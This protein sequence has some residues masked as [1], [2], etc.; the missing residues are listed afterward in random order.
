MIFCNFCRLSLM[1]VMCTLY[2]VE[3]WSY[4]EIYCIHKCDGKAFI[5]LT[6]LLMFLTYDFTWRW[7]T[8]ETICDC[9]NKQLLVI[10]NKIT[11]FQTFAMFWMLYAFFWV[12]PL[13]LN[14]I[15]QRS[16]HSVYSIF[17]GL[18]RWNR[19]S[20]LNHWHIK[21]RHRG[22]IQKKSYNN[23]IT[24]M[25]MVLF[26]FCC[27]RCPCFWKIH[28]KWRRTLFLMQF[29]HNGKIFHTVKK[30]V[31]K[32][33]DMWLMDRKSFGITKFEGSVGWH[34]TLSTWHLTLLEC[35]VFK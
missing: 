6:L 7:P 17:I 35:Y 18:W 13:C 10:D 2:T 4:T 16:E 8:V 26:S 12:I 28:R 11:W 9:E 22:I 1:H 3:S 5:N 19:Q 29:N 25:L 27:W 33:V 14:I 34:H 20:V 23:K 31:Y 32:A 15:S 30:E 21:F 24:V